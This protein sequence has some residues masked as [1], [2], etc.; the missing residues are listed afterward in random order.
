MVIHPGD[1]VIGDDD[2]LLCVPY[3]E[4]DAMHAAALGK[5]A[6]EKKMVEDIRAGTN[7]TGWVDATLRRLGCALPG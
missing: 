5:V 1:L 4:V 6:Y 2:G 7:D 3:D